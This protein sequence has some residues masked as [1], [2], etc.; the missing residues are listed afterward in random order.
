[1]KI[2]PILFKT[3]MVQAIL[4]RTKTQTRRIIKPYPLSVDHGKVN[5]NGRILTLNSLSN[6]AKYQK[7]D[8]LWVRETWAD[9]SL[10]EELSPKTV[11]YKA[12]Y[13]QHELDKP[14]NKGIWKPSIFMPKKACRIWLEVT[15]V[16]VERLQDILEKD[17]QAEGIEVELSKELNPSYPCFLCNLKGHRGDREICDDGFFETA[18][19]S[20]F[21][22]WESINGQA[23]LD[24][25]SWVWK[26][27]FNKCEMPKNFLS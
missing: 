18:K 22:L 2:K 25:N 12:D 1:M 23:S 13:S 7:G 24:A 9:A 11:A 6:H 15:E 14:E 5:Y 27:T 8:I 4:N 17:A 21:S 10:G 26:Y 20:F 19:K 3:S 16:T